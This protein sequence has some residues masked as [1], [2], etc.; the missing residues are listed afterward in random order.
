MPPEQDCA[1]CGQKQ[2]PRKAF[3]EKSAVTLC[4]KPEQIGRGDELLLTSTQIKRMKKAVG[5]KKSADLKMSKTHRKKLPNAVA[6]FLL[7]CLSWLHEKTQVISTASI[8]SRG[9]FCFCGCGRRYN[10]VIA[11]SVTV[12][13]LIFGIWK[14]SL[15]N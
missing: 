8:S 1:D 7:V 2:K 10:L 12:I 14:V 6:T 13:S 15:F 4:V 11:V 9:D 3:A 5:E